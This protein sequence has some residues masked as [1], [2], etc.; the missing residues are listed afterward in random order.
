MNLG[1]YHIWLVFITFN[2]LYRKFNL[3]VFMHFVK[4]EYLRFLIILL[5]I[6]L[7]YLF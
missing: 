5:F 1:S 6:T 3:R 2:Y 4:E 7:K